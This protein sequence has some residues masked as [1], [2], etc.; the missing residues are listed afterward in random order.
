M[1]DDCISEKLAGHVP[2]NRITLAAKYLHFPNDRICVVVIEKRMNGCV[3]FPRVISVD[4]IFYGDS[5]VTTWLGK[6]LKKL[7][8]SLNAKLEK[9]FE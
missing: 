1:F 4:Y 9:C 5:R 8:N 3:E 6:A 7:D 2:F